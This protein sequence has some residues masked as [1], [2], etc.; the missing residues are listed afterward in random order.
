M[1]NKE[2]LSTSDIIKRTQVTRNALRLYE[3]MGLLTKVRRTD[4]GYRQ[5]SE[6]D[7]QD[8]I[9]IQRAKK[10][11]F[12]LNEIKELLVMNR[13][14]TFLT[15]GKISKELEVKVDQ[16]KNEINVLNQKKDFLSL[17]LKVCGSQ[18][19]DN[20]CKVINEGFT[21]KSCC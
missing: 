18:E 12:T 4:S 6:E 11:G 1:I 17:F 9:F 7:L 3:E 16:I 14:N 19:S 13:K 5:Y 15:C 2:R 21:K 8:L 20:I 10:I